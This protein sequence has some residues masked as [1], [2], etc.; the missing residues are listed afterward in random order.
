M[1]SCAFIRAC[2]RS[3]ACRECGLPNA[4]VQIFSLLENLSSADAQIATL[5]KNRID[6]LKRLGSKSPEAAMIKQ[7]LRYASMTTVDVDSIEAVCK[8]ALTSTGPTVASGG[9]GGG[10]GGGGRKGK[11][12]K[13]QKQTKKSRGAAA[14]AAAAAAAAVDPDATHEV[15]DA[16]R[17]HDDVLW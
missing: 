11:R 4:H 8:L 12:G 17:L 3:C 14:V 15:H 7:L 16:L 5:R 6:L 13:K 2:V 9:G 10:G 1:S